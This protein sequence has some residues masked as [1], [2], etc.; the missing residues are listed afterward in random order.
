MIFRD[1]FSSYNIP[2]FENNILCEKKFSKK[3]LLNTSEQQNIEDIT[4][5]EEVL[6][7]LKETLLEL[8]LNYNNIFLN[9]QIELAK[10]ELELL[11]KQI[12][13]IKIKSNS[14][15]NF[16]SKR[17]IF[18][19][20]LDSFRNLVKF[21][22]NLEIATSWQSPDYGY[23]KIPQHGIN[24]NKIYAFQNDY[25]RYKVDSKNLENIILN[26]YKN[27]KANV[28]IFNSGIGAFN[29]LISSFNDFESQVSLAG[30]NLY[31][32]V[33]N[34]LKRKENI[35]FFDEN[36]IEMLE[37]MIKDLQPSYI[38]LDPVANSPNLTSFNLSTL[39]KIIERTYKDKKI[40]IISDIT[41]NIHNFDIFNTINLPKNIDLYLFRSLQKHDQLGLD[42]ATGGVIVHY[43]KTRKNILEELKQY[44]TM[45]TEFS[46]KT[47]EY[48]SV[49]ILEK[50]FIRISQN[51]LILSSYLK[52]L[53]ETPNSIIDLVNYPLLNSINHYEY[54]F[55]PLLFFKLK[56]HFSLEDCQC[57]LNQL[58]ELALESNIP[59]ILGS[60][61]GF[62][63]PRVMIIDDGVSNSIYFR[64]STGIQTLEEME[65]IKN[66]FKTLLGCFVLKLKDEYENNNIISY[67]LNISN[68]NK[69]ILESKENNYL[70]SKVIYY[71]EK[72]NNQ[73]IKF[74]YYKETK[75]FYI[76]KVK[77][78]SNTILELISNSNLSI[79]EKNYL[80]LKVFN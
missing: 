1:F 50:R 53:S 57:M 76:S 4:L 54:H 55:V 75:P 45:P 11:T 61:F 9:K 79:E 66:L 68:F 58:K 52:N 16:I 22:I 32:E 2:F 37:E 18:Y 71:F 80:K 38:F 15:E 28:H 20:F 6:I 36:D 14:F 5:I 25:Q 43:G 34:I 73:L 26:S 7:K 39:F 72:I 41:L 64:F 33:K 30:N 67:N 17:F 35:Y 44:G 60:S 27:K 59:L 69:L 10:E 29:T 78:Y 23:S 65:I 19:K 62:N 13:E 63:I 51:A 24:Q 21:V 8:E 3:D 77:E 42:L 74:S 12:N 47:L 48:F 56:D 46:V 40:S 31:F 49:N 70:I